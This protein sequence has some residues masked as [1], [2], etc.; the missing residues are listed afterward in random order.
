MKTL[1]SLLIT[2]MIDKR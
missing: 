1:R 2:L